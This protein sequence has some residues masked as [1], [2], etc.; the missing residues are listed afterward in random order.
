MRS[1]ALSPLIPSRTAPVVH[2]ISDAGPHPYF[3]TLIE[4]PG[5]DRER[6]IVGCVGPPGPLQDDMRELGVA[7]FALGARSRKD[8]PRAVVSLARRLRA[9]RASVLQSHLVDGSLVGLAA[10]RLARVP[11]AVFT[12]HHSHELPFHG[13]KLIWADRMCAGPL[14]DVVIAPSIQVRDTLVSFTGIAADKVSVIHHGFDLAALDSDHAPAA[15]ARAELGLDGKLVVGAVGRIYELKNYP[16]LLT[17]FAEVFTHDSDA[18]LVIVGPGEPSGL[19]GLA[20]QLGIADRVIITGP[21]PD[22][23]RLLAAFDVFVHP[24]IAESFG[25]V[26]IEAMLSG[27]P[28]ISTPVGIAP[29]V[30]S[31][32]V[33]GVLCR[34]TDVVALVDGLRSMLGL[35]AQWA[36]L[37]SAGRDRVSGFTASAMSQAYDDLYT[38]LLRRRQAAADGSSPDGANGTASA[39]DSKE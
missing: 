6:V 13:R 21:R 37:G 38:S 19:L 8:Y 30:I 12:A 4:S 39:A 31:D 23:P 1:P 36:A 25:M 27:R 29:E 7:T 32:G 28:T 10:A 34:G 24:A 33:D 14:S 5:F 15:Q 2:V 11:L 20:T 17:A 18:C 35:R 16:A 26:I 9:H 3:R 22:V